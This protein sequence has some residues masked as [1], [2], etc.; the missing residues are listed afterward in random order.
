MCR[1]EEKRVSDTTLPFPTALGASSPPGIVLSKA[2]VFPLLVH[3]HSSAEDISS[4]S[5]SPVVGDVACQ[6][7]PPGQILLLHQRVP[8]GGSRS[9]GG[10]SKTRPA[11]LHYPIT[12]FQTF[13]DFL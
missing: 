3:S 7:H 8:S 5:L 9:Q 13:T 1:E 10:W 4:L 12:A 6:R 2:N 11:K